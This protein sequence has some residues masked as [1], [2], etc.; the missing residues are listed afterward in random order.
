MP[1]R[2]LFAP[3]LSALALVAAVTSSMLPAPAFAEKLTPERV[4]ADPDINGPTARGVQISPDGRFVTFLRAK[5]T[6]QTVQDL[7]AMPIAGGEP[8]RLV[9]AAAL[10]PT[11]QQP[12]EAEKARRERQRISS[13]GI[14]E[15]RW[16]DDGKRLLVPVGGDLYLADPATGAATRF[17]QTPG[18]ESD[19]RF[20]PKGAWVSWDDENLSI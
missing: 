1:A 3:A 10:S 18:T 12:S 14:V 4:F 15:Y 7:W 20:S 17:T 5:P 2:P 11:S 19:S 16:D 6:D 9:D 8:R 13:R